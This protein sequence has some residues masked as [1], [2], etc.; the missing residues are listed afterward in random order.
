MSER[1]DLRLGQYEARVEA[2][3]AKWQE[4]AFGKRLWEKDHQLWSEQPVPELT[5]P[6]GMAGAAGFA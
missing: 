6:A 2:R 3:L 5:R 4:E 1:A